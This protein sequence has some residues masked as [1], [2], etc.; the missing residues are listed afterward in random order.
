M[1]PILVT[2]GTG[3]LGRPLVEALT[4]AG[5]SLRVLSRRPHAKAGGS[6]VE[7]VVGDLGTGEGIARAVQGVRAIVHCA[8]SP[9]T[10]KVDVGGTRRL[11]DAARRVGSPHVVYISI[12]GVDRVPFRYYK[13]K[14]QV[15][16]L[17]EGSGLPWTILRTTQFHDL[18]LSVAQ[19]LTRLPVLPV[20]R[21]ME[22]QPVDV[23]EVAERLAALALGEPAGRV[24]D[25][26]GPQVLTVQEL[27]S[28][29]LRATGRRRPIVAVPV[30]G[31]AAR[32]FREGGHLCPEHA[33]G[34]RTWAEFLA[35]RFGEGR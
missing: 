24:S 33:D 17:I 12:V 29:Y 35:A 14:L 25:M 32:G 2:G 18:I 13:A 21:D 15:E 20:P 19:F 34:K 30:P 26:G 27:A 5:H 23:G 8:T 4:G 28:A 9:R 6:A 1:Q 7:W 10:G 22:F 31:A 11:L 3:T 16:R